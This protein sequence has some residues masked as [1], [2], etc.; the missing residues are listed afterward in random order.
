MELRVVYLDK[1][2]RETNIEEISAVLNM[3]EKHALE[4][5]PWPEFTYQT[6]VTFSIAYTKDCILL[7]YYISENAIRIAHFMDNSP[8]YEDSCVEFFIAFNG[9]KEYYNLEFNSSGAC[10]AGFG[11][12]NTNRRMISKELLH[13][14]RRLTVIQRPGNDYLINWELTL[15]L[16]FELFDYHQINNLRDSH[17]KGNFY[18]CGDKLPEPHFLAWSDIT[19]VSPDFHLS[20]FFGTLH[21]I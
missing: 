3:A 19:S 7:K 1:I 11:K 8:V 20:G 2:T 14:I 9:E 10:L 15:M 21:F 6:L 13:K 17:C 12:N 5:Q 4:K 18:K 16:P